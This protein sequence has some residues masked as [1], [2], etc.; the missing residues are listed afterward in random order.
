MIIM[1]QPEQISAFWPAIKHAVTIASRWGER[2]QELSN[3][4]LEKL[5]TGKAQCWVGLEDKEDERRVISGLGITTIEET[6]LGET[7]LYLH[8]LYAYTTISESNLQ[9]IVP[10]LEKFCKQ[11]GCTRMISYT[12]NKRLKDYYIEQ[13]FDQDP[14][15]FIKNL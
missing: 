1:L 11:A 14:A 12:S 5:L 8:S 6:P 4:V 10:T 15:V 7:Y 2:E 3:K 9:Q 13:G